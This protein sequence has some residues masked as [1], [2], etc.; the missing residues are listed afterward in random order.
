MRVWRISLSI[1]GYAIT[2]SRPK[3]EM[4]SLFLLLTSAQCTPTSRVR[5]EFRFELEINW[6]TVFTFGTRGE[7]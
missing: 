5:A 7:K 3:N 1:R 6:E 4:E 2:P